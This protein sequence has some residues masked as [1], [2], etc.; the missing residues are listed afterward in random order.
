[1]DKQKLDYFRNLLLAQR[2]QAE[3]DLRANAATGR[4][5]ADDVIDIGEESEL[6]L[7]KSTALDLAGRE[8]ELITEIDEAL[9]R[10]EDGTYGQC[11]RCGKPIDEERLKAIPTARYDAKCQALIEDAQGLETPTL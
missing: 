2:Q 5:E 6:D 9:Q 10:I 7:E 8:S 1:M 11:R 4:Q 3:Q